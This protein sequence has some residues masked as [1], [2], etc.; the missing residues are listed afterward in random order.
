MG[1]GGHVSG[2]ALVDCWHS[3]CMYMCCLAR[4]MEMEAA[5]PKF[6]MAKVK[7]L[8]VLDAKSAQNICKLT[9]W[10]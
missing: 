8:K 10:L 7:E 9:W 5:K 4:G 3:T 2:L 6:M 1:G